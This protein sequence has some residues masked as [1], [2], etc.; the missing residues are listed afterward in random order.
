[1]K[2]HKSSLTLDRLLATVPVAN[3]AVTA[4]RLGEG[5]HVVL[6]IRRRWW[7]SPPFSWLL[8]YREHRTVALD[9]LGREVYEA[10]D[11]HR[12]VEQIVE[13]FAHTHRLRFHEAR[14]SV[15][16]FL[17]MLAQRNIVILAIPKGDLSAGTSPVGEEIR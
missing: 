4:K 9:A 15:M 12:T 13:R 17:K 3:R 2:P 1:M 11:G 8:P 5:M 16:Q 10:V 7:N 6:P 14:L